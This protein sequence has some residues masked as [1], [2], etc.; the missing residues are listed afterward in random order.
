MNT[1]ASAKKQL[2]AIWFI[3]SISYSGEVKVVFDKTLDLEGV[4]T[5]IADNP[6][7]FKKNFKFT[8]VPNVEADVLMVDQNHTRDLRISNLSV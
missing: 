7:K 4:Q 6:E 5:N 1:T 8:V 3:E 2:F